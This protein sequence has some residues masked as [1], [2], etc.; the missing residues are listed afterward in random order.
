MDLNLIAPINS[1]SYGVCGT[2]FAV[3]LAKQCNL[4]LFPVNEFNL[5]CP[6]RHIESIRASII[7][8]QFY[9]PKAPSVRIWHQ[10]NLASHVG[11]PRI[12]FPIFELDDF[13]ATEKHHIESVDAIFVTSSWAA[14]IVKTRT[15]QKNVYVTPLGVD[16]DI[17]K[18]ST[19]P[20]L[21]T[22]L[23]TGKWEIRKSHDIIARVLSRFKDKDIRVIVACS[24][25][26]Y[27]EEENRQ[28]MD[29]FSELGDKV[30]FLGKRLSSQEE[31]ARIYS[32]VD[33]LVSPSRAEG[34]N[35]PILEAM[36]CGK[37]VITTNYSAHTEFCTDEN[38]MLI[39]IDDYIVA[40]DGKFFKNGIGKWARIGPSQEEKMA[41]YVDYVISQKLS[42]KLEVNNAGIKTAESLTWNNCS[43]TLLR[44]VNCVV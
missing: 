7:N 4:S 44:N 40:N 15:N 21:P 28:W 2:N 41:E 5:E 1:L 3:Q 19:S 13:T 11:S 42:G 9:N 35:L 26:F 31:Y 36:S 14:D 32:M 12:G 18:P 6:E 29:L 17:F 34:W 39:N 25:P 8:C 23:V 37:H 33:C 38:S 43:T 24:N 10:H 16:R 22:F 27:S 30:M 20:E